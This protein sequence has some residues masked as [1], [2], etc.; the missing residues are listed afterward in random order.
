MI[1]ARTAAFVLL[2]LLC[3]LSFFRAAD[4]PGLLEKDEPRYA[5]P[6][7]T[8]VR[9]GD[10]VVP[11]FAGQLRLEK[12]PG[13]YWAQAAAFKATGRFDER[14]ARLPSAIA[15]SLL[16]LLVAAGV[17]RALGAGAGL[18]AGAALAT[19]AMT[20]AGA[21]LA[22]T[23]ML[24]ALFFCASAAAWVPVLEGSPRASRWIL[25][26]GLLAG[27]AA[28]VKTPLA[29]F[30]PPIAAV[31]TAFVLRRLGGADAMPSPFRRGWSVRVLLP[32]SGAVAIAAALFFAW[33][34]PCDF[35]TGGE[36]LRSL[37]VEV[38]TR[39]VAD[40]GLHT[41]PP[42]YFAGVALGG[43]LPWTFLVPV[44]A[45]SAWRAARAPG[46]AR[47]LGVYAAMLGL[48]VFLFFSAL[49]SKLANYI[50]PLVPCAAV[51]CGFAI[52]GWKAEGLPRWTRLTAGWGSI[53]IGAALLIA[54]MLP[55]LREALGEKEAAAALPALHAL[56]GILT[57]AGA[58]ALAG[59][60]V[61]FAALAAASMT[62]FL[63]LADPA[64]TFLDRRRC[65]RAAAEAML[66]AGLRPG[67]RVVDASNQVTG[68]PWYTDIAVETR[69]GGQSFSVRVVPSVFSS[70]SRAWAI[71]KHD[72]EEARR[73]GRS[74]AWEDMMWSSTRRPDDVPLRVVWEGWERVIVTNTK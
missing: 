60:A 36:L 23:D 15:A 74:T 27:G 33:F 59:R 2:P 12:P 54:P 39:A 66:A 43:L 34:I 61:L 20:V 53:A 45:A 70:S 42:W 21:R 41:Q 5:V 44:G 22:S 13:A 62:G 51:L 28:L 14:S 24:H 64:V 10:F 7:R 8:M 25:L 19:M 73:D 50:L 26:S 67:D 49:P 69:P 1:S 16:V 4:R 47:A 38:A 18:A 37:R 63:L 3:G 31:A 55:N 9:T 35:A 48:T 52:H 56:G 46:P 32:W 17:G 6:A 11:R 68:V 30:L 57:A 58:A 40:K 71:L 72:P 29:L 65:A